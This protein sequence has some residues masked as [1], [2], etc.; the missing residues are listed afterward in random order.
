MAWGACFKLASVLWKWAVAIGN[1][2]FLPAFD[3]SGCLLRHGVWQ[4]CGYASGALIR[5]LDAFWKWL[6]RK[7]LIAIPHIQK[8]VGFFFSCQGFGM[9]WI[10]KYTFLLQILGRNLCKESCQAVSSNVNKLIGVA[11]PVQG[12]CS[13]FFHLPSQKTPTLLFVHCFSKHMNYGSSAR[14]DFSNQSQKKCLFR[15][16]QFGVT[17]LLNLPG[18]VLSRKCGFWGTCGKPN[19]LPLLLCH[20]CFSSVLSKQDCVLAW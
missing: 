20:S 19:P 3:L 8:V 1:T 6:L 7:C 2:S 17:A 14:K 10:A 16:Q 18:L 15:V 12:L 13:F 9:P 11:F 4:S 5:C